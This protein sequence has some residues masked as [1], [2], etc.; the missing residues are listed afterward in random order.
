ME[1]NDI[2]PYPTEVS[3]PVHFP[4]QVT[5]F[6]SYNFSSYYASYHSTLKM[7]RGSP[8]PSPPA[9]AAG[10]PNGQEG[11]LPEPPAQQQQ[12]QQAP[13]E[14][15]PLLAQL[16]E[17]L[18]HLG[19]GGDGSNDPLLAVDPNQAR[20]LL[21]ATGG[22]VETAVGLFLED[23]V[24]YQAV[25]RGRQRDAGGGN[26][27]NANELPLNGHRNGAE[28]GVRRPAEALVEH[29]AQPPPPPLPP[30]LP[31]AQERNQQEGGLLQEAAPL[32]PPA[33]AAAAAQPQPQPPLVVQDEPNQQ[34]VAEAAQ[35]PIRAA[36]SSDEEPERILKT[37][38]RK[39]SLGRRSGRRSSNKRVRWRFGDAVVAASF[40]G[41]YEDLEDWLRERENDD[42]SFNSF[43]RNRS[44]AIGRQNEQGLPLERRTS[45]DDNRVLM[46]QDG[47]ESDS[48]FDLGTGEEEE[49]EE[50]FFSDF[51]PREDGTANDVVPSDVLWNPHRQ[52]LAEEETADDALDIQDAAPGGEDPMD[53]QT[54]AGQIPRTWL[55]A[56]FTLSSCGTGLKLRPPDTTEVAR[57]QS[58]QSEV[59]PQN[60]R[61]AAVPPPLPTYHCAGITALTSFVTGLLYTGASIQ[62]REVNC[63]SNRKSFGDLTEVEKKVEFP[64][65]LA[66][67]L[68]CILFVAAKEES[69]RKI[70]ILAKLDEKLLK[71][72]QRLK[73]R[74]RYHE[75]DLEEVDLEEDAA[76][77]DRTTQM[78][79]K[80]LLRSKLVPVCRWDEHNGELR[81]PLD[82][83]I[84]RSEDL[85]LK[86]SLTNLKDM[87]AYVLSNL[88]S[89]MGRGGCAL[90]M[91][92]L[93][94]IR[95]RTRT[96]RRF[97][98]LRECSSL[99]RFSSIVECN[100]VKRQKSLWHKSVKSPQSQQDWN[101]P[102]GHDCLALTNLLQ[103]VYHLESDEMGVKLLENF[104]IGVLSTAHFMKK[105]SQSHS[106]FLA[107]KRKR[108]VWIV[109]GV[110]S[111]SVLWNGAGMNQDCNHTGGKDLVSFSL[112]H[113]NS[114]Y[115]GRN[116]TEF[117]VIPKDRAVDRLEQANT[118]KEI[119][120]KEIEETRSNKS[121]EELYPG[122]YS[123]WR[124]TFGDANNVC[125][126][127]FYRLDKR[128]REIVKMK[129]APRVNLA[130]WKK[131]P[132]ATID[133]FIPADSH[134][135]V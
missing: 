4:T 58:V 48:S 66:D 101:A 108:Q 88:T 79:Q 110:T 41:G 103:M 5:K 8:P 18:A 87:K 90:F 25:Q 60:S 9:S 39:S 7:E 93:L 95:G 64:D 116:K 134:P 16:L 2:T 99:M 11:A 50:D 111:Y 57:L 55:S 30:P 78:R 109:E 125:D 65:R 114:W 1:L 118:S 119:T 105:T 71:R 47:T 123:R 40:A 89:F 75:E 100:C 74:K 113:W 91:E 15:S 94:H 46:K 51:D 131:W 92:A 19:A 122:N 37:R 77:V 36:V 12:Q 102:P 59:Y 44:R 21:E 81:V 49:E 84:D 126:I 54:K 73:E 132:G 97:Q 104:G 26:A 35:Q 117:R 53:Q 106:N 120:G 17:R 98:K 29:L 43:W 33:L 23:R 52:R 31:V 129:L 56:G 13:H 76:C 20:Y 85:K 128:Q 45:R 61:H 69:D 10:D 63:N 121:D 133:N 112:T 28:R 130:V 83:L 32:P 82:Q 42:R 72:K 86:V 135:I 115:N 22:H 6:R 38:K 107:L 80:M 127:P 124:F 3:N 34:H 70:R 68:S 14:E 24:A 62:G 67:A 27:G 96:I